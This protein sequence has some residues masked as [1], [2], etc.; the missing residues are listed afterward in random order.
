MG[1]REPMIAANWKM[2]TTIGEGVALCRSLRDRLQHQAGC[3]IVVCP[4]FTHLVPAQDVLAGTSIRLGAQN[5]H[6]QASGAFTGEI[7]HQMLLG[8]VDY[9]ILGH[10]E[11]RALFDETDADVNRKLQAA[12]AAGLKPIFCVGE[13]GDQRSAGATEDVL[14]RQVRDGLAGIELEPELVVAYEPVW[15]IGT[16]VPAHGEQAQA[17]IA[18]IREQ[19]RALGG[20]VADRV[21]I[22]YGGSVTPANIAEFAREPDVDGA[23]VGGASL[24]ADGFTAIVEVAVATAAQRPSS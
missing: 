4:P 8:L 11:R 14:L 12:V 9:V 24:S 17:A 16:G 18:F 2:N 7:S 13:T 20:A 15:A 10:S 22:L 23:L 5:M 21:R 19:V 1:E 6:W 3:E